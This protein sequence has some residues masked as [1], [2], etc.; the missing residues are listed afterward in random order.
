MVGGL[1]CPLPVLPQPS[2]QHFF[3]HG[4]QFCLSP[5]LRVALIPDRSYLLPQP[6]CEPGDLSLCPPSQDLPQEPNNDL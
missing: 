2:H 1:D 3:F 4:D 5:D 6:I